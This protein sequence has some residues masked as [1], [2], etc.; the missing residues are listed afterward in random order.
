MVKVNKIIPGNALTQPTLI[1][2]T[3]LQ[4]Q[5]SLSQEYGAQFLNAMRQA[6]GVKRNEKAIAATQD[7]DHRQRKLASTAAL[8]GDILLPTRSPSV[9]TGNGRAML[10]VK[11]HELLLFINKRLER[12]RAYRPASTRC[13]RRW[14]SSPSRACTD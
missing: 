6:V 12:I 1:T 14:T 5:N 13:A 8:T 7:A 4:M 2:Q 3:Q 11:Q 9:L 10:T